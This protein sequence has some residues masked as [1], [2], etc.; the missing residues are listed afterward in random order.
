MNGKVQPIKT[1]GLVNLETGVSL[2]TEEAIEA[3]QQIVE[4]ALA[5]EGKL[6]NDMIKAEIQN[7]ISL[8]LL[9]K[10]V[11][12][13]G[14]HYGV[15]NGTET[16]M[17]Y[18]A[19]ADVLWRILRKNRPDAR[20]RYEQ[21]TIIDLANGIIDYDTKAILSFGDADA[22]EAMANANSME[23]K[24]RGHFEKLVK[25]A[26]KAKDQ[27]VPYYEKIPNKSAYDIKNTINQ[28]SQKRAFVRLIRKFWGITGEMTQDME[29]MKVKITKQKAFALY[30][31]AYRYYP[32]M[33][34]TQKKDDK[35][36]TKGKEA[37]KAY[38]S[39]DLFP[40]L[41]IEANSFMDF[42]ADD[43]TTWLEYEENR[44]AEL[45]EAE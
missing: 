13:E 27:F 16:K 20:I 36:L 8:G 18:Q 14:V 30:T 37:V 28:M 26:K 4:I 7:S 17:L 10:D 31:K 40:T 11:F 21:E 23:S 3:K 25:P 29:D 5:K 2:T 42:T 33:W 44:I 38:L 6:S 24:F 41:K 9:I 43:V 22:D 32:T 15:L 39:Q 12:T 34:K 1:Y 35:K 19:G 45:R